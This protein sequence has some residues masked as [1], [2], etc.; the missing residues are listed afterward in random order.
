MKTIKKIAREE[1]EKVYPFMFQSELYPDKNI[2][3]AVNETRK[4][5]IEGYIEARMAMEV[6]IRENSIVF[7]DWWRNQDF[8]LSTSGNNHYSSSRK[9]YFSTEEVYDLF[10]NRKQI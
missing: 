9:K 2:V 3:D 6:K 5:K 10:I 8:I 4:N 1:A 7:M